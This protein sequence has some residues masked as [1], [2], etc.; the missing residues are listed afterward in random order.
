M[1]AVVVMAAGYSRITNCG[2]RSWQLVG[3][4]TRVA[5]KT[6]AIA[7]VCGLLALLH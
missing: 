5:T 4:A 7:V 3:L 6:R 1:I 2:G